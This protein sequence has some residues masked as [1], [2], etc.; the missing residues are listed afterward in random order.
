MADKRIT[1]DDKAK[2]ARHIA[3]AL[4]DLGHKRACVQFAGPWRPFRYPSGMLGFHGTVKIT[5]PGKAEY[6]LRVNWDRHGW[7]LLCVDA[8]NVNERDARLARLINL[9]T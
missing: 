2:I 7:N 6:I 1:R 9:T 5:S 4:S 3:R 8:Y